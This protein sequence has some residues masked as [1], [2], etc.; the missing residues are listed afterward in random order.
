[1][2]DGWLPTGNVTRQ[3]WEICPVK[4][5]KSEPL[6]FFYR[7]IKTAKR[8]APHFC[9]TACIKGLTRKPPVPFSFRAFLN[10]ICVRSHSHFQRSKKKLENPMKPSRSCQTKRWWFFTNPSQEICSN[11]ILSPGLGENVENVWVATISQ[12]LWSF[13]LEIHLSLPRSIVIWCLL[14]CA[15]RLWDVRHHYTATFKGIGK[16]HFFEVNGA[17][18]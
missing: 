5:V 3:S 15:P 13:T 2:V 16:W 7:K 18:L 9:M 10:Q 14:A 1:M 17:L 4:L 12:H 11:W 8:R 6:L